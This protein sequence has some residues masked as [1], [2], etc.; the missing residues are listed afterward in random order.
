M[1]L[2]IAV[3]NDLAVLVISIDNAEVSEK[4]D[5]WRLGQMLTLSA[6]LGALLCG[7]SFAHFFIARDVF[8]VTEDQLETIMYLQLSSV[9]VLALTRRLLHGSMTTLS[10]NH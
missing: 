9:R 6:I 8:N 5:K 3:L 2:I 7:A 1:I 10:A 4:P